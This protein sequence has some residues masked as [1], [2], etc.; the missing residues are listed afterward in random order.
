MADL[1]ENFFLQRMKRLEQFRLTTELRNE[2]LLAAFEAY[3]RK[4]V[5]DSKQAPQDDRELFA[6]N[7]CNRLVQESNEYRERM[8]RE[9]L[10]VWTKESFLAWKPE[11]RRQI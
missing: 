6:R 11:R 8:E 1:N 7:Y 3:E 2:A 5:E 4:P 9:T 10:P